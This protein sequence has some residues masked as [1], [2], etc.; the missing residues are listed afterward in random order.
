MKYVGSKNK[1]AKHIVPILQSLIDK[2]HIEVYIEPFVG[3]GN[4]IDKI[5]CKSKYGFDIDN[6]P[7]S[8]F[9]HY[10]QKPQDLDILPNLITKDFYYYIRD[11]NERN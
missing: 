3:G 6:I 1:I 8:I 5:S 4:I 11:N 10:I 2:N 9:K 7:I